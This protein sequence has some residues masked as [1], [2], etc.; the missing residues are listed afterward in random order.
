MI[1]ATP[2]LELPFLLPSQADKHVNVNLAFQKLDT[3]VQ[4]TVKSRTTGLQPAN[5][6]EGDAYILPSGKT[7]STWQTFAHNCI[8]IFCDGSWTSMVPKPGWQVF[9]ED[10]AAHVCH[11]QGAWVVANSPSANL[12]INGGFDIWQRGQ[13]FTAPAIGKYLADRW[14]VRSLTGAV[15]RSGDCPDT[16]QYSL[17][18]SSPTSAV[19]QRI[20]SCHLTCA[21]NSAIGVR[22]YVKSLAGPASVTLKLSHAIAKDNFTTVTLIDSHSAAMT[23]NVWTEI[24]WHNVLLPSGAKDGLELEIAFQGGSGG[25]RIACVQAHLNGLPERFTTLPAFQEQLACERYFEKTQPLDVVPGAFAINSGLAFGMIHISGIFRALVPFRTPKSK[26]P[27]IKVYASGG[28]VDYV[29]YYDGQWRDTGQLSVVPP[30]AT[31]KG[32]YCGHNSPSSFE[33][34]FGWTAEAEL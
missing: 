23:S 13:T 26:I 31:L 16:A 4:A 3:L 25:A 29:S 7:G 27:T 1:D 30:T 11:R 5:P 33:T 17:A 14:F 21:S 24:E 2:R 9:V 10:E 19:A 15:S 34:Q 22:A 8:A 6:G 20:E 18:V 12:L 32:F 28:A